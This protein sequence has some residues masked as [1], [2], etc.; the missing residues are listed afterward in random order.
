MREHIPKKHLNFEEPVK[1]DKAFDNTADRIH[2]QR[3]DEQ[4]YSE[5]YFYGKSKN[6]ADS[7]PKAGKRT[8]QME[9]EVIVS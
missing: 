3:R 2:G 6:P 8:L 4:M 1:S 5:N 7:L 9:K